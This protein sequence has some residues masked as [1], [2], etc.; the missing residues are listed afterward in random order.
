MPRARADFHRRQ[1]VRNGINRRPT[2]MERARPLAYRLI[3]VP[4]PDLTT[5]RTGPTTC[6]VV[7]EGRERRQVPKMKRS[8]GTWLI[9]LARATGLNVISYGLQSE[10][11]RWPLGYLF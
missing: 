9:L 4:L 1:Q 7:T 8:G 2:P 10:L 6:R 11:T 3:C 5:W